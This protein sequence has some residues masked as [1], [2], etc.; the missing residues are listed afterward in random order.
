MYMHISLGFI[1]FTR[2]P[3]HMVCVSVRLTSSAF[4]LLEQKNFRTKLIEIQ[5]TTF[6]TQSAMHNL[7]RLMASC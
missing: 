7:M 3:I 5:H 6:V 1:L 4:E 2:I